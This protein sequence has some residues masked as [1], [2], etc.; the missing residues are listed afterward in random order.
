MKSVSLAYIIFFS[1]FQLANAQSIELIKQIDVGGVRGIQLSKN[2]PILKSGGIAQ[3]NISKAFGQFVQAGAGIGYIQLEK[4]DFLPLFLY[5]KGNKKN[6]KNCFFFETSIGFSKGNNYDFANSLKTKY[7]A[8]TYFSPGIGY[9]Y[10]INKNWA[11]SS[12]INYVLQKAKLDQI[13][14]K[15]EVYYSEIL[16]IDLII[17]KLGIIIR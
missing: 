4:E 12:G 6:K 10:V 8:S 14:D 15:Q 2:F 7:S 9:Q 17:F 13:N 1:F 3:V 11:V 16:S 5:I